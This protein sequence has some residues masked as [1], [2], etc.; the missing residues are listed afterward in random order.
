MCSGFW[1]C[2]FAFTFKVRNST[3]TTDIALCPTVSG[4]SKTRCRTDLYR[5]R[6]FQTLAVTPST[7]SINLS[8]L[9]LK[10]Q[11]CRWCRWREGSCCAG[12]L[13][14]W[15][16]GRWRWAWSKWAW[17]ASQEQT[18][19][20]TCARVYTAHRGWLGVVTGISAAS[21]GGFL[22]IIVRTRIYSIRECLYD[23]RER[24]QWVQEGSGD[25]SR[26]SHTYDSWTASWQRRRF[27]VF[28]HETWTARRISLSRL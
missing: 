11:G 16:A 1:W 21:T 3:I 9:L 24:C 18:L 15:L 22:V 27:V 8:V 6:T 12:R 19:S 14:G 17:S 28:L 2:I 4:V 5:C 7:H 10:L 23:S 25:D 20:G 13:A 26:A